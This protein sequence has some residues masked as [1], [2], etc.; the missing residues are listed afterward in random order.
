MD[1]DT[2]LAASKTCRACKT[3]K[4][5]ESFPIERRNRDGRRGDCRDC[6]NRTEARRRGPHRAR[7]NA[8]ERARYRDR[9]AAQ[10]GDTYANQT[11]DVRTAMRQSERIW[12]NGPTYVTDAEADAIAAA[13][14]AGLTVMADDWT[15][16]VRCATTSRTRNQ[17]SR[18]DTADQESSRELER[19]ADEWLAVHDP[20]FDDAGYW[21]FTSSRT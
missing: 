7:I 5:V 16:S 12:N 21:N 6:R 17:R 15:P 8:A 14:D 10:H 20:D 13:I 1:T 2:A 9:L 3:V 18:S 19:A 4:P 11:A